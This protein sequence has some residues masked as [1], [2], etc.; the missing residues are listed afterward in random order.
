MTTILHPALPPAPSPGRASR[1]SP[2]PPITPSRPGRLAPAAGARPRALVPRT[3]EEASALAEV[4]AGSGL[5]P[6][7]FDTPQACLIAILHG[8]ELGLTPLAALQRLALIEG[9]PTLWGDGAL[10]LVRASGLCH[11]GPRDAGGLRPGRLAGGVHAAAGAVRAA[12]SS[13]ASPPMMPGGPGSGAS[14][15]RGADYPQRM[16]QMRARA[17]ALRDGFADVLGGLYLREELEGSEP[18]WSA[19]GPRGGPKSAPAP[20]P[21]TY[22][23]RPRNPKVMR[24]RA[25]ASSTLR[26]VRRTSAG[27]SAPVCP[28]RRSEPRWTEPARPRARAHRRQ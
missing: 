3:L 23:V 1:P 11:R 18:G 9:R 8:L 22:T 21:G 27:T 10:A 7:G 14:P 17:F 5:A 2:W 26:P 4:I 6:A 15:G 28:N 12:S 25:Y 19:P 13:G 24:R 16:L 20:G